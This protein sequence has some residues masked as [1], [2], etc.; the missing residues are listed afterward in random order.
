MVFKCYKH[1]TCKGTQIVQVCEASLLPCP[2]PCP[3][4]VRAFS[5]AGLAHTQAWPPA[6][7]GHSHWTSV[8]NHFQFLAEITGRV[9]GAGGWPDL[10]LGEVRGAGWGREARRFPGSLPHGC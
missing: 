3:R 10:C 6:A 9:L 1:T 2:W 7:S 8:D 4:P 5:H